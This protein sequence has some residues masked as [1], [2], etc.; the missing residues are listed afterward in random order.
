MV[1][2]DDLA[3]KSSAEKRADIADWLAEQKADAVVLSALDS[4]AWALNVR[5]A[6]VERT[7]VALAYAIA[8]ADGT[9]DLFVAPEKM[10]DEVAAHLGNA[11]RVHDRKDFAPA[12]GKYAGKR[13]AADPER[14]VAAIFDGLKAG[15]ATVLALRDPV[16]LAKAIKN[17]AEAAGHRAASVRDGAALTRFLKWCEETLPARHRDR[18][19]RRRQAAGIARGDRRCSRI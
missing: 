14:A 5:G 12:L 19:D 13:V 17:P 7:P 15:G 4:I 2:P 11:V 9:L 8:N 6:D 10:S 3:G 1:Q 16:V 18:I